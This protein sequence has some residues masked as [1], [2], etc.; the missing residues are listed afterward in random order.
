MLSSFAIC[1]KDS[2]SSLSCI[3][4]SMLRSWSFHLLFILWVCI[5]E[6]SS[7]VNFAVV[8]LCIDFII[9]F[10]SDCVRGFILSSSGMLWFISWASCSSSVCRL[11]GL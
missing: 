6:N 9:L 2:P 10:V 4:L 3:I 7:F 8:N 5:L 1:V 11:C